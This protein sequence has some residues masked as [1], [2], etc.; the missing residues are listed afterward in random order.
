MTEGINMGLAK[1][2]VR[3]MK[4][5]QHGGERLRAGGGEG[6]DLDCWL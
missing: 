5:C 3:G 4:E 2:E 6:A 1:Q